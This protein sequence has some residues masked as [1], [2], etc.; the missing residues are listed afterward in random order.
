MFPVIPKIKDI[1]FDFRRTMTVCQNKNAKEGETPIQAF[2]PPSSK[3]CQRPHAKLQE[4]CDECHG[5]V[6]PVCSLC[7][8]ADEVEGVHF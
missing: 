8:Y 2:Q 6:D 3:V 5:E 7:L 1:V 4:L